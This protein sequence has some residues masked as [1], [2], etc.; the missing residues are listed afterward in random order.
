MAAKTNA[1]DL[2]KAY[3]SSGDF[4]HEQKREH[5]VLPSNQILDMILESDDFNFKKACLFAIFDFNIIDFKKS[6]MIKYRDFF[7]KP[8][9]ISVLE[10][11]RL[12]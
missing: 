9:I 12:K 10:K 1:E 2:I 6:D 7:S 8:E 4:T 11:S 3:K 5:F